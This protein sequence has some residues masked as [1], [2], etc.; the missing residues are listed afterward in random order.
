MG[1][2]TYDSSQVNIIVGGIPVTGKADGTFLSINSPTERYTKTVGAD[3]EVSR[4]KTNDNTS[5][6]VIT[7]LQTSLTNNYF[8]TLLLAD[9]LTNTG[10]VSIQI[11]DLS[12]SELH[13]WESCWI[14]Q[15]PDSEFSKEIGER[16]WTFDTGQAVIENYG[17]AVI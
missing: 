8:S 11:T 6:I 14:R 3:G 17:G 2:K 16:A 5:E 10:V 15:P 4:V 9:R 13:F 1:I 12:G 7:L